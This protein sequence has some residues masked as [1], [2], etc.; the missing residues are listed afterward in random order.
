MKKWRL[1][2]LL[3]C[4][5]VLTGCLAVT[6]ETT[7]KIPTTT[8]PV[9]TTV[10][11]VTT[12][13]T[14][15]TML[16]ITGLEYMGEEPPTNEA[17]RFDPTGFVANGTWF[18]H[19]AP[20][21][22]PDGTEMYWSK[23]LVGV[24]HIQIWFT[25]YLEGQWTEAEKLEIEGLEGDTNCPV[26]V[27][28]DEGLYLINYDDGIFSLYRVTRTASGWGNPVKINLPLLPTQSLGWSFSIAD[29]KN[30]YLPL[31]T[32]GNPGESQIYVLVNHDGVYDAPMLIENQGSGL[33]GNGDPAIA[34]NESYLIFMSRRD[35]GYGYHDLYISFR[36]GE[37]IFTEPVS[38]GSEINTISEE[39]RAYISPDGVYLF[40]TTGKAGDY[41]YNPY[42][43]RIDQL[44]VM[45][46]R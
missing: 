39:G 38:L 22:S 44:S 36:T 18:W 37:G 13:T 14:T 30:I 10:P 32:L 2:S 35:D 19:S 16:P 45:D 8:P 46:G 27:P 15:T 34:P 29:N 20:V 17:V 28:G 5:M 23:Y 7:T 11:T 33:Y 31:V 41:G 4:G 42:W 24:D 1:L 12:V 21:F 9:V 43:I 6:T 26:F 40:F 25:R 3:V